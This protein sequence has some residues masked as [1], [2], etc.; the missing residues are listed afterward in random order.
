MGGDRDG[1]RSVRQSVVPFSR[2]PLSRTALNT[3]HAPMRNS[4]HDAVLDRAFRLLDAFT[5]ARAELTLSGLAA[6]AA[7]PRATAH[8]L[9]RQLTQRGALERSERGWRLG[10]R[11]FELGQL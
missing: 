7:L 2:T 3:L 8:R 11:L 9:A 4:D 10:L 5:P 1:R 6:A